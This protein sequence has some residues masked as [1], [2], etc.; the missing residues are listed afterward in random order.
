MD[1][2]IYL[3]ALAIFIPFIILPYANGIDFNIPLT[4]VAATNQAELQDLIN[5]Q[6]I[7]HI[8]N[9]TYILTESLVM[10]RDTWVI[11]EPNAKFEIH[12]DFNG[13]AVLFDGAGSRNSIWQGG[14]FYP[15]DWL[16]NLDWTAFEFRSDALS[17]GLAYSQV[18]DVTLQRVGTGILINA[19]NDGWVNGNSFENINMWGFVKGIDFQVDD[20]AGSSRNMFQDIEAQS[21]VY[22]RIGVKNI[23]GGSNVFLNVNWWDFHLADDFAR[24]SNITSRGDSTVI[25]GGIM[26]NWNFVDEGVRTQTM[27]KYQ[28]I[29]SQEIGARDIN[30]INDNNYVSIHINKTAQFVV[31][32]GFVYIPDGT[33]RIQD[34]D[35]VGTP[36]LEIIDRVASENFDN[37]GGIYWTAR[38]NASGF[39][40]YG[41]IGI[42]IADNRAGEEDG[43]IYFN[44]EEDGTRTSYMR[45]N[46][47]GD[48]EINI[49]RDLDMIG[50]VIDFSETVPVNPSVSAQEGWVTIKV[51]GETMYVPY[52]RTIP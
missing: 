37:I 49:F 51:R 26:T 7:V 29:Q 5:M 25:I 28:G 20:D 31:K 16:N 14:W 23:V 13:A 47:S 45:M 19:T 2:K 4:P 10:P 43:E 46:I 24:S 22:T 50:S 11:A 17:N 15:D 41:V 52:Y 12:P 27:D 48:H 33:F 38:N 34:S 35:G 42:R 9:G 44:P 1:K 40:G 39:D 3:L 6:G 18:K 36:L 32:D 8:E 30:N 21:G